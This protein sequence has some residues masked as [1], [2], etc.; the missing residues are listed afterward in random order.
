MEASTTRIV[1]HDV[2]LP[3]SSSEHTVAEKSVLEAL[4]KATVRGDRYMT[5]SR[6]IEEAAS[7]RTGESRVTRAVQSLCAKGEIHERKNGVPKETT[8]VLSSPPPSAPVTSLFDKMVGGGVR[9]GV[10]PTVQPAAEHA[11]AGPYKCPYCPEETRTERGRNIHIGQ[12]HKGKDQVPVTPKAS[13]S[14]PKS[15]P[16]PVDS[17]E[18]EEDDEEDPHVLNGDGFALMAALHKRII[19]DA[20]KRGWTVE[21]LRASKAS[22]TG[23]IWFTYERNASK[24]AS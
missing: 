20:E 8:Y 16:S 19:V 15:A 13:C 23:V 6:V 11:G 14:A 4:R 24:V 18:E 2:D 1:G 5:M 22:E 9:P 12:V 3:R 21:V 17:D 7:F 10:A